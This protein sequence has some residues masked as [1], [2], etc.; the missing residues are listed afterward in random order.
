MGVGARI[1][2]IRMVEGFSAGTAVQTTMDA[3]GE[4][5]G[6]TRIVFI[7][8]MGRS[9]TTLLELLLGRLEGWVAGGELRRYWHGESIPGWICGCGR[10]L[11]NCDFWRQVRA[12]LREV[13]ILPDEYPRFLALQHSHLRVRPAPMGR[14]VISARGADDTLSPL[15]RY[16]LGMSRLYRAVARTAGAEVV[17]DSSKQPPDAY[18]ATWNPQVEVFA[19]HLV[20]DPRAVAHS[21]SKRVPEPQPDLEYMPHS[22]PFGTAARWGVRQGLCEALLERR[23]GRRYMRI[24]YEDL[25]RDPAGAVRSV[26]RFARQPDPDLGFLHEGRVEFEPHHTFSGNPLRLRQRAIEVHPDEAWRAKMSS[27]QKVLATAPVLPLLK[28]YGYPWRPG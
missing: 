2:L 13:G 24:R 6:P 10:L 27:R 7:V 18:L 5:V 26:A 3:E 12:D 19:V 14:L 20:R 15:H 22:N 25:V 21:F 28:R 8:G 9:G 4:R 17:V 23:L 16:Q 1:P 11:A